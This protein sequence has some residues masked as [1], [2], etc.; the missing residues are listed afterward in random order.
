MGGNNML[1]MAKLKSDLES[2]KFTDVQT[3]IQSG[4]VVFQSSSGTAA[5][6]SKMISDLIESEHGFRPHLI[7]LKAQQL[8]T[9]VERNPFPEST[10]EPTTLH[11]FFL[12]KPA[13]QANMAALDKVKADNEEYHLTDEVFYLKAPDGVGRSKLA[14]TAEKH[15]GVVATA[16]N[17]RTVEK[18]LTMV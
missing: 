7:L 2:L 8:K 14:A 1:P 9:A 18:L 15:L 5:S 11:F 17:Y 16:R 3:Y 12:A 6:L 10:S 13:K 4:N